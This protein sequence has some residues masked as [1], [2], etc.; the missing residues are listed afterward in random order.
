MT[1]IAINRN[2]CR[3]CVNLK[4]FACGCDLTNIRAG[5]VSIVMRRAGAGE[6]VCENYFADMGC[7]QFIGPKKRYV[8]VSG[9]GIKY[10]GFDM[11][12][13]GRV[14]FL[15]DAKLLEAAPGR[16]NGELFVCDK[17]VTTLR[18][19]LGSPFVVGDTACVETDACPQPSACPPACT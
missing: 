12:A 1:I 7:G 16:W 6:L 10:L 9:P 3:T 19:Q 4:E 17:R 14:C 11:D 2:I 8:R 15:W 13:Q 5:D 18:F